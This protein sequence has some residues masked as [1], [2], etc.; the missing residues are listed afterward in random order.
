MI[1]QRLQRP[2]C[3]Q[4][5]WVISGWPQT[6]QQAQ[7]LYDNYICP[8]TI[9]LLEAKKDDL[10]KRLEGRRVDPVTGKTWHL[11]YNIPPLD[12][13]KRLKK[14]EYSDIRINN[15]FYHYETNKKQIRDIFKGV[16]ANIL[17]NANQMTKKVSQDMLD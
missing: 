14:E 8:S 5:G 12:I 7:L 3:L 13:L 17:V 4:K 15:G 10:L 2:D 9:I 16:S 1:K 11:K 6:R